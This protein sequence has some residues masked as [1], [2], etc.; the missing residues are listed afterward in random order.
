MPLPV[1]VPG[2]LVVVLDTVQ[3]E[4]VPGSDR[5]FVRFQEP[6]SQPSAVERE[7]GE[8][9]VECLDALVPTEGGRAARPASPV[10]GEQGVQVPVE[11]LAIVREAEVQPV[12]ACELPLAP[13][14]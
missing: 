10:K 12:L 9:A 8:V 13:A 2:R 1:R 4:A 14:D 11:P 3:A 5:F 6:E 7:Q